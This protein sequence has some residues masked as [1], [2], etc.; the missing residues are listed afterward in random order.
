MW[1][2]R[3]LDLESSKGQAFRCPVTPFSGRIDGGGWALSKVVT[4]SSSSPDTT[5]SSALLAWLHF[6]LMCAPTLSQESAHHMRVCVWKLIKN[7]NSWIWGDG[8][9]GKVLAE[10]A[11]RLEF[12]PCHPSKNPEL[13]IPELGRQRQGGSWDSFSSQ[14]NLTRR[15]QVSKNQTKK[16]SKQN[17]VRTADLCPTQ[18]LTHTCRCTYW[19]TLYITYTYLIIKS[20][21]IFGWDVSPKET[22]ILKLVSTP[23]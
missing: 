1:L 5:P 17:P 6:L 11:W 14:L 12:N 20:I 7:R 8:S 10:Q 23:H 3:W 9:V 21:W 16:P 22:G 2:L 13:T 19:Y 18:M 4:P 15:L